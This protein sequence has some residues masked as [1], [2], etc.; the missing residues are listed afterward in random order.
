MLLRERERGVLLRVGRDD[1]RV[2]AG[3]VRVDQGRTAQLRADVEVDDLVARG[4]AVDPH[5]AVLGLAVLVGAQADGHI[6]HV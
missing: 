6:T 3:E 2:V 1:E 4:V 5:D